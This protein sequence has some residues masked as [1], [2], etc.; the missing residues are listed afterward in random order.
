MNIT[1]E[2]RHLNPGDAHTVR[3]AVRERLEG[4]V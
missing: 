3:A 1:Q 4:E 2:K